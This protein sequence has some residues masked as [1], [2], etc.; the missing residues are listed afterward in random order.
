MTS[1][2]TLPL[3]LLTLSACSSADAG[4]LN[5]TSGVDSSASVTTGMFESTGST[6]EPTGGGET[7]GDDATTTSDPSGDPTEG[8]DHEPVLPLDGPCLLGPAS[9]GRLAVI[10]NDLIAPASLH[11]L[12]LGSE[13]LSADIAP[14][15]QDP[16]LAWGDGK[17]VVLG[18]YGIN[19]LEVLDGD[20]YAPLAKHAV[21]IEGIGDANPQALSFGPDGRA[22]LSAF[23]SATLPIYDLDKPPAEAVVGGL[24]LAAFADRDGSPE[25]G[26]SFTCGGTLL[27]G[28]QRLVNFV[29]VDLSYLVALDLAAGAVLDLDP[30]TDGPQALPLLGPWPKQVRL[31]PTDAAGQTVLVLTS[32]IERVDLVHAGSSWAVTPEQLAA[33]DIAGY[34][35]QAFEI[36][37]DGLS[38]FVLATDGD[39]PASAVYQVALDGVSAPTPLVTGLT[40]R[41]KVIERVDDRLWIGDADPEDPRLRSFDLAQVPAVE[42]APLPIPGAPYL[43]LPIP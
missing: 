21:K 2:P 35:L 23:A 42:L 28:V 8:P 12:D 41:E 32:G 16:A 29:P 20:S 7:T 33:V 1:R 19:T 39:Y 10:T 17:L 38:A 6:L 5:I 25:P 30:D 13:K 22:Y 43:F 24:D 4:E 37:A 14:V 27:V 26:V 40:T 31:D 11:V 36:A 9:P 3:L 18:R 34:D 15:S